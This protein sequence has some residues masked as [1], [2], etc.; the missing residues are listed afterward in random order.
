MSSASTQGPSRRPRDSGE[1]QSVARAAAL[2]ACF[3]DGDAAHTL[4]EL[5]RRTELNVST[6]HRLLSTLCA[7]GLLRRDASGERYLPG[8]LL[9]RLARSSLLAAGFTEVSDLLRELAERTRESVSLGVIDGDEVVVLASVGS[10]EP[11]RIQQRLG[12]RIPV[13]CSRGRPRAARVRRAAGA[14][15]RPAWSWAPAPQRARSRPSS[16]W[17]STCSRRQFRGFA[18]LDEENALG[19]RS[20]A[21]PVLGAGGVARLAL[22]LQGPTARID[23]ARLNALAGELK[24]P[25]RRCGSRAFRCRRHRRVAPSILSA[26]HPERRP[27]RAPSVRS[28]VPTD[29]RPGLDRLNYL[30]TPALLHREMAPG[31]SPERCRNA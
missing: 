1:V 14:R 16:S 4:S 8:P 19:V 15:P 31:T 21:A 13:A 22:E 5:A 11:L 18:L 27:Y 24:A 25:W 17:R 10:P 30:A 7:Q 3:A 6:A 28:A 23:D 12:E 2:L 20:L 29:G 9:L 26:V